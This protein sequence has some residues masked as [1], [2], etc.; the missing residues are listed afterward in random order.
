MDMSNS[1]KITVNGIDIESSKANELLHWL[2]LSEKT[3]IKTQEKSDQKMVTLIMKKIEEVVQ[4][5]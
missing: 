5:Y 2:I 1:K 3:N 4:C